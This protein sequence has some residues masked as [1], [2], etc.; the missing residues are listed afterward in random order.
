MPTHF[1]A[2]LGSIIG[3]SALMILIMGF[4]VGNT[5]I[6]KA[7]DFSPLVGAFIGGLLILICV[8]IPI[9][10]E[11]DIEP[12]LKREQIAWNLIGLGCLAWA[13]GECFWRYFLAQGQ[14]TFP[15]LADVGYSSLPPL[16]FVGLLLQPFSRNNRRRLFLAL[17]SLIAM[18]ALLSIAWFLLLGSLAEQANETSLAKFLGLYYPIADVALLSCIIFLFLGG[19]HRL[20][21]ARARRIGL[22]LLGT[23]LIIFAASDFFFNIQQNLNTFVEESWVDL[24]WPLGIMLVGVAAYCRRFLP[25]TAVRS[26]KERGEQNAHFGLLQALPYALLA[27]LF[28]VLVL[29]MLAA[30]P[31]QRSIRPVLLLS[32]IVVTGLVVVRQIFTL[33]ENERLV[34]KQTDTLE[35]LGMVYQDIEKRQ[36][37]LETGISHLKDVQTR[38]ANGDI[39]A[40]AQQNLSN[41]LWPLAAGIN[42]M[43]DRLLRADHAQKNAQKLSKAINDLDQALKRK[44]DGSP[45][46]LPLSCVEIPEIHS[47]IWT[48]G[49]EPSTGM[50]QPGIIHPDGSALADSL[51]AAFHE[52]PSAA[53]A[54]PRNDPPAET[55]RFP[56]P[57]P[58][59]TKRR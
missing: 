22:L 18:G 32:T 45:F 55:L 28:C 8:N 52:K 56:P 5:A 30:D 3:V 21:Q 7:G 23:G 35:K 15:S 37:I 39:T 43:A 25:S 40:R 34:L 47:L 49:L 20:Y 11:E 33:L 41:D 26:L 46:V 29:N 14:N 31:V 16:C 42:L 24:G 48:L 13:I 59:P 53:P 27:L 12:W 6:F 36:S 4:H 1:R 2:V 58:C 9:S 38:L 19:Q 44:R 17:D 50:A 54:N 10:L 57:R 51:P